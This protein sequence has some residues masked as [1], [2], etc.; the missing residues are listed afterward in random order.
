[1]GEKL[2]MNKARGVI[3]EKSKQLPF[4]TDPKR[5]FEALGGRQKEFNWLITNLE[6]SV[7]HIVHHKMPCLIRRN[8]PNTN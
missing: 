3:L 1:M 5:V 6:Y 8:S 2:S 7:N 4:Y